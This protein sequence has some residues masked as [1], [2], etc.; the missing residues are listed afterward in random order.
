MIYS[1]FDASTG[2]YTYFQDD[3]TMPINMDL[4]VPRFRKETQIGVAAID[5]ARPMPSSAKV[6][7]QGWHARGQVVDC[8]GSMNGLGLDVDSATTW[9]KDGGWKWIVGGLAVV[10]VLRRI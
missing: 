3:G 10:W 9:V 8:Q 7:G 2:L 6:V 4:P 5:A 1:C